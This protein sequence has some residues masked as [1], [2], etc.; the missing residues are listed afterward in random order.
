M[1]VCPSSQPLPARNF[2]HSIAIA[3][4][5]PPLAALDTA[6]HSLVHWAHVA[7][8]LARRID[9][10]GEG[11]VGGAGLLPAPGDPAPRRPVGHTRMPAGVGQRHTGAQGA[12]QLATNRIER[13]RTAPICPVAGHF[14]SPARAV[15]WDY[16]WPRGFAF[17]PPPR[18]GLR[19]HAIGH[20]LGRVLPPGSSAVA[21]A[22]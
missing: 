14:R 18:F 19:Q 4:T 13:T 8:S 21:C 1:P 9:L 3:G 7:G 10:A 16:G 15:D 12:H 20:R 22:P 2:S 6:L 17:D 11:G 5:E